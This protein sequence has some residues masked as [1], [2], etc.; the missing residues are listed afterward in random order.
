[1][2]PFFKLIFNGV[3]VI[4]NVTLVSALLQSKSVIHPFFFRLF[5]HIN[6]YCFPGGASGK[7]LWRRAG[8]PILV[9]LLGESL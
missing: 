8:Q 7:N 2:I 4:Y 6:D 9:F 3:S 5:P 1:M